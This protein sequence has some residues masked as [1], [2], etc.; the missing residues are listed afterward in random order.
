MIVTRVSNIG[1]R[2]LKDQWEKSSSSILCHKF[3][4]SFTMILILW[5]IFDTL[6]S[7]CML[8]FSIYFWISIVSLLLLS[9]SSINRQVFLKLHLQTLSLWLTQRP[10]DQELHISYWEFDHLLVI[11]FSSLSAGLFISSTIKEP[12]TTSQ[13]YQLIAFKFK[14]II[15][16]QQS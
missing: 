4:N 16:F 6:S 3:L 8:S 10:L 5:N 9:M 11:F 15:L 13:I 12:C 7:S 2:H 14:Y 1:G